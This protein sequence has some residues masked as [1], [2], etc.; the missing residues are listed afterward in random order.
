MRSL[1]CSAKRANMASTGSIE[2]HGLIKQ[3]DAGHAGAC[4]YTAIAHHQPRLWSEDLSARMFREDRASQINAGSV[5]SVRGD[6]VKALITQRNVG[7]LG[8][9][10]SALADTPRCI[11]CD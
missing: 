7:N 6:Q 2:P 10:K 8:H 11:A 9:A 4:F 5:C 1:I 3:D